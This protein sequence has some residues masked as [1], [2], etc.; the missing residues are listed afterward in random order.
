MA[1]IIEAIIILAMYLIGLI[2][3]EMSDETTLGILS[4]IA[5]NT[6][7]IVFMIEKK[8]RDKE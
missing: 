2:Y 3:P 5:V 7:Y 1:F 6:T 8:T 4:L